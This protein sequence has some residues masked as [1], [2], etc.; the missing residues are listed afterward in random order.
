MRLVQRFTDQGMRRFAL[1]KAKRFY[2]G[3]RPL[4]KFKERA[5]MKEMAEEANAKRLFD[6]INSLAFSLNFIKPRL[7]A[8]QSSAELSFDGILAVFS[9]KEVDMGWDNTPHTL[10]CGYPIEKRRFLHVVD[11]VHVHIPQQNIDE[12]SEK[13]SV[14][15]PGSSSDDDAEEQIE[16]EERQ[17]AIHDFTDDLKNNCWQSTRRE[18]DTHLGQTQMYQPTDDEIEAFQ[19]LKQTINAQNKT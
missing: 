4:Q 9:A 8:P 12:M 7:L 18:D 11:W 15:G 10:L 5:R 6:R 13:S 3:F 14:Y 16:F 2:I 19:T 1:F 17:E